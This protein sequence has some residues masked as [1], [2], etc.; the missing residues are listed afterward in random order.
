MAVA[1]AALVFAA[2]IAWNWTYVR[3]VLQATGVLPMPSPVSSS[4]LEVLPAAG[5]A[6]SEPDGTAAP[7]SET[8][9]EDPASSWQEGDASSPAG[10]GSP[11]APEQ[12]ATP[13]PSA[14]LPA[15]P[16]STAATPS[17]APASPTPS[18]PAASEALAPSATPGSSELTWEQQADV[19]V[20]ALK[21]M[22]EEYETRMYEIMWDAFDEYQALPESSR[23]LVNKIAIVLSKKG[24]ISAMEKECDAKVAEI[25]AELR[26]ILTENGQSTALA[27]QAEKEY[28]NRKSELMAELMKQAYSGGDGSGQSGNWLSNQAPR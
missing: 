9:S 22:E 14:S 28:K 21:G 7:G 1:V 13:S 3:A 15:A 20:Q 23:N 17:A 16:S 25:V 18:A 12:T 19:Q 4:A 10:A 24:D 26:R 5:S 27:D 8:A 11:A 2:I 6:A